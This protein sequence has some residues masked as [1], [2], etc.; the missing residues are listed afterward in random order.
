MPNVHLTPL[1]PDEQ[2]A[3][4]DEQT[5]DHADWL[6]DQGAVPNLPAALAGLLGDA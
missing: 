4:A 3:F 5:A 6:A 1:T 2:F